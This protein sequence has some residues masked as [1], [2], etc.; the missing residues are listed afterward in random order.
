MLSFVN[1]SVTLKHAKTTFLHNELV[2]FTVSE[3]I[4]PWASLFDSSE[5]VSM[6]SKRNTYGKAQNHKITLP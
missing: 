3:F 1:K 5:K 6:P 4:W 2:Y